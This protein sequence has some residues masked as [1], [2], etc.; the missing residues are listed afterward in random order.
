[1]L[2]I[3]HAFLGSDEFKGMYGA[4]P[5][6]ASF[7]SSLYNNVLHRAPEQSGYD[8]W[9]NVVNGGHDRGDVL[10]GFASSA[11]NK[12]NVNPTM[13][14]GFDYIPYGI[15][16]DDAAQISQTCAEQDYLGWKP[17]GAYAIINNMWN[18]KTIPGSTQ[19][20]SSTVYG[21]VGVQSAQ[22]KWS[23]NTQTFDVHA[24]PEILVGWRQGAQ[25]S[26][27]TDLPKVASTIKSIKVTGTADTSCDEGS[28][29]YYDTAFDL[30]F[31]NT[32]NPY[33]Y[34]PSM[35]L[36]VITD[37]N[38]MN[39]PNIYID[40]NTS[41][42]IIGGVTYDVHYRVMTIDG[43]G[44]WPYVAYVVKTNTKVINVDLAD[45]VKDA[46]S[47]A[48]MKPTDA[49]TTIEFGTEVVYGSGTT[50]INGYTISIK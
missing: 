16:A 44:S 40:K 29:C 49:L 46:Q 41:T 27:T 9:L 13:K 10:L 4:A 5:A 42:A 24:Y 15:A 28:N 48:Y 37:T 6:A 3:A 43:V 45:F 18:A 34:K 47:R 19:C 7:V 8:W 20:V 26:T 32:N 39:D 1:M 12:A 36:M 30:W 25:S 50:T 17:V 31:Q 33:Q 14:N 38:W 23:Y 22:F 2:N 21:K 11:E 35:E